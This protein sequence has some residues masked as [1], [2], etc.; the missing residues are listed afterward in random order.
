M[1]K[2]TP[3]LLAV[4]MGYCSYAQITPKT[5]DA[6]RTSKPVVI[7]GK[8]N[9]IAWGDASKLDDFTEFRPVIGR[10]ERPEIRTEAFIMYDDAG[11]Y[12]GGTCYESTPDLSSFFVR[13]NWQENDFDRPKSKD[14]VASERV[15]LCR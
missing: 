1:K 8:L 4:L 9:E 3:L 14:K 5:L 12:F 10:K 2:L 6:K 13:R 7:D 15:V 11:I